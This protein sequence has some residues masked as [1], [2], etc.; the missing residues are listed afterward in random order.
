[1]GPLDLI[2]RLSDLL[3][4]DCSIANLGAGKCESGVSG[5]IRDLPCRQL[6][7][8]EIFAPYVEVLNKLSYKAASV[9][10]V[11]DDARLWVASRP[12]KSIDI[13]LLIDVLEHFSKDVGSLVLH[14]CRRAA[15]KRVLI[16]LPIGVC[17]Q[18]TY[19][20]NPFQEHMSTWMLDDF[21]AEG[22]SNIE[23]F[24]AYHTHFNPPVDA[25]WITFEVGNEN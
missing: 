3:L 20:N 1:M 18:G 11:F 19:D 10:N 25:A 13:I 24:K 17:I 23:Y 8:V 7:N 5:Q 22:A 14:Y 21:K 9:V 12:D 15:K 16:W 2:G 6:F 4:S